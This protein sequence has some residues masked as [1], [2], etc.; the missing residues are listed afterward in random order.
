MILFNH[1]VLRLV[2]YQADGNF[3]RREY[4]CALLR[5]VTTVCKRVLFENIL[6]KL[7][8][9][10]IQQ[11][12]RHPGLLS[13]FLVFSSKLV[14]LRTRYFIR[15]LVSHPYFSRTC[16]YF[17]CVLRSKFFSAVHYLR[18]VRAQANIT[19][20]VVPTSPH[21]H[22]GSSIRPKLFKFW[23]YGPCPVMKYSNPRKG[24]I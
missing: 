8:E 13:T 19:C 20:S 2:V 21:S 24:C 17:S 7:L 5:D 11:W 4:S 22:K 1:Q 12:P 23:G 14:E 18:L 10:E 15:Q 16:Q 6:L 9:A 3:I